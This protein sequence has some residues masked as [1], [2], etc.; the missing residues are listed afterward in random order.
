MN[1]Q[2]NWLPFKLNI[3]AIALSGLFLLGCGSDNPTDIEEVEATPPTSITGWQMVWQDEF[4][5][6]EVDSSK[7]SFAVDC[8]GGG[9]DEAQCYTARSENSQVAQGLL[10]I[11]ALRETFSGPAVN[12]SDPNYDPLDTS[13]TLDYTSARLVSKNKGDW[14]YGRFEIRAK[15]PQGQGTWP[16]IWMLPTDWVYGPWAGSG[17][18][19]I[20][21][22]V[23]LKT[24]TNGGEPESAVHGTLHFGKTWPNNVYSGQD[25][26]LPNA[27]NPSDDFHVY[28][29][30][31]QEDEIRWYVD[32]VH[33]ATQRSSGWYSQYIDENGNTVNA[34]D[35]APFNQQF[36]MLL[37]LAVG[38]SWA[39][40]VNNT[41]IDESVFPQA[42]QI[43]YVRVYECADSPN[44]GAGCA[45]I[46]D[47]AIIVPGHSAPEIVIPDT[48]FGQGPTFSLFS[49]ADAIALNTDLSFGS[50][51]PDGAI[52]YQV[53][54]DDVRGEVLEITKTAAV[55]N[56]FFEY[57]P[58]VDL[59]HW[60]ELGELVFDINVTSIGEGTEVLVKVDSGWPNTGDISISLPDNLNQWQEVRIS[61]ASLVDGG[62][63]FSPGSTVNL[64][65]VVNPFVIEPTGP[66]VLKL[67]NIR[68]EYQVA[69]QTELVVYDDA[70]VAPYAFGLF[71]ASGQLLE[72]QVDV[73]GEHKIVT[74]LTFNTNEAVG[75][76]QSS[77]TVMDFS[78]FNFLSF[79]LNVV[80]DLR[81][82]RSMKIKMDCQTPCSSGDFDIMPPDVG[83]W[84]HYDI[85]LTDLV[86]NNGSSLDLAKVDTPIVIFPK[87]GDQQGVVLQIDNIK[88]TQ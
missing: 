45:T 83:V 78:R 25:Y 4:D 8:F 11:T 39:A 21:E 73:G 50:Y 15:L 26:A 71:A 75:F 48:Q 30:E 18:I 72:E 3:T 23:N 22:A 81:E 38:G 33:Y 10:T 62:N 63:R 61:F 19:D 37:N 86:A 6:T 1:Q 27:Q 41:G 40:N 29:L 17:E 51:N 14:K 80:T 5:G 31:W 79:D 44:T 2:V 68:Y 49:Y 12:D 87:W 76:Y 13:K 24:V 55:G 66:V 65:D 69:Q 36:H 70:A 46:D 60:Q 82:V 64:T 7:W 42:M 56:L 52:S 67:D 84:T 53:G 32:D 54:S 77:G 74:Q 16:A 35:D 9:N 20:M 43:D 28:A 47:A 85:A 57:S 88:L 59:S 34:P 58:R